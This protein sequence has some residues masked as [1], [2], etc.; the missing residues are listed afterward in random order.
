MDKDGKEEERGGPHRSSV[1][2]AVAQ[3]GRP[4]SVQEWRKAEQ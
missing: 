2:Q 3:Q 4:M 1:K